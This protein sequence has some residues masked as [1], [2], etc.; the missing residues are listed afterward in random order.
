M[1][2]LSIGG[3]WTPKIYGGGQARLSTPKKKNHPLLRA[4]E[5]EHTRVNVTY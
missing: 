3:R 2:P 4:S 5:P 1:R